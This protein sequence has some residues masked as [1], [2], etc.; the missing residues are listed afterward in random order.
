MFINKSFKSNQQ[1]NIYQCTK[2]NNDE[3]THIVNIHLYPSPCIS[4]AH[5]SAQA[6]AP[7]MAQGLP[8]VAAVASL[9]PAETCASGG[10][11]GAHTAYNYCVYR[12]GWVKTSCHIW[13][14][15]HLN[16]LF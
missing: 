8:L 14:K 7:A 12:C 16:Q 5:A 10:S 4:A 3:Q 1:F 15:N 6:L 13:R 9:A 2:E 11:A